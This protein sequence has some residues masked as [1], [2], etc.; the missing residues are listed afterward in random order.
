[1]HARPPLGVTKPQRGRRKGG[2]GATDQRR[3]RRGCA[4]DL[5]R[6]KGRGRPAARGGA[7]L[8]GPAGARGSRGPCPPSS[9]RRRLTAVGLRKAGYGGGGSGSCE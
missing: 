1:M 5:A 8:L 6:R 7:E 9:R 2:A 3:R 4:P